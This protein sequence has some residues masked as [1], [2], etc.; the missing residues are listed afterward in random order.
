MTETDIRDE[1]LLLTPGPCSISKE[2][3]E[4][5]LFDL[6]SGEEEMVEKI[7]HAREYLV[8]ICNGKESHTAIPLVGSGTY[9][10]EAAI[11]TFVPKD[12]K[13]LLH[14]NG[15]YGDRVIDIVEALRLPYK[16]FRTAPYELPTARQ[17]EKEIMADPSITHVMVIHCET[18]TGILN[19]VEEIAQVCRKYGKGLLIDAIASF[20][21]FELDAKKLSYDAVVLSANKG[22][23]APPGIA[24]VVAK[25]ATLE[26]CKGNCHS[27]SL[28]LWD[29]HQHIE[30]TNQ[31]R[32]TPAT[33]LLCAFS[34]ALKEHE[35]EGGIPARQARYRASWKRLVNGMRQMGFQTLLADEVAS[36]IV[37]TFHDPDDPAYSFR[38]LYDGMKK[39]GFIIFPGRL[40][41]ANT[42]RIA[43]IGIVTEHDI[44]R[45]MDALAEVM[46]EM[47]VKNF[48]R[49]GSTEAA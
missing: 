24:W 29:Q 1:P 5:M 47:G 33:H 10:T 19:P 21:I 2:V 31:F 12:G 15:V 20:G 38:K 25:R 23:Q 42:F 8:R 35:A 30:R 32:F 46:A 39:R 45:A 26:E 40:A 6:A 17:F 44:G 16:S 11:G 9:A 3:K 7:K 41:A 13:L 28:D 4:A 37:A 27:L 49:A 22:M 34:A 14:T 18:S 43:C 36:P 48:G